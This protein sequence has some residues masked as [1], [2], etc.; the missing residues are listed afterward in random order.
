MFKLVY[1]LMILFN[2]FFYFYFF[3]TTIF[4]KS[5]ISKIVRNTYARVVF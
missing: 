1:I 2:I 5:I 3:A 4:E